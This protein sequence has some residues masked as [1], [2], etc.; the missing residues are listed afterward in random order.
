MLAKKATLSGNAMIRLSVIGQRVVLK[1]PV[2]FGA[3]PRRKIVELLLLVS[4]L[5]PAIPKEKRNG[6]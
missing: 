1:R 2:L 6:I 3:V 4:M 5:L